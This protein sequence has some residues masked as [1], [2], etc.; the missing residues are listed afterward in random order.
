MKIENFFK[1]IT[2]TSLIAYFLRLIQ[3]FVFDLEINWVD[4]IMISMTGISFI[5]YVIYTYASGER[6]YTGIY[7]QGLYNNVC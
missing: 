7:K 6:D 3:R 1:W 2:I 4:S 5:V